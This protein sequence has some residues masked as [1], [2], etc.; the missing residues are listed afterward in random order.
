MPS[1]MYLPKAEILDTVMALKKCFN[2]WGT[3]S[4]VFS[5][6]HQSL[7][8]W[9]LGRVPRL[10]AEVEAL[11]S[12]LSTTPPCQ[13]G[14]AVESTPLHTAPGLV[15][16]NSLLVKKCKKTLSRTSVIFLW[17]KFESGRYKTD[18]MGEEV[19]KKKKIKFYRLITLISDI[20]EIFGR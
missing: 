19:K 17:R 15:P 6:N 11:I 9:W 4:W 14:E 18:S 5:E 1:L 10:A 2:R 20:S 12:T 7:D 8:D 13:V 16:W 3:S